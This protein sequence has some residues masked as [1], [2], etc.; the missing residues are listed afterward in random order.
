MIMLS[1][2]L[3]VWSLGRS[4]RKDHHKLLPIMVLLAGFA[5][6]AFG[7]FSGIA[8]L[9]PIIIPIGGLVVASAHLINMKLMRKC[10]H[11]A[12]H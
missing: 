6:I 9:E 3:G 1:I 12:S 7:H 5:L 8:Q 2:F 10:S 4:Y 11:K